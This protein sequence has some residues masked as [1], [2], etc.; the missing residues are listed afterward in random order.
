M[1]NQSLGSPSVSTC[2]LKFGSISS[3]LLFASRGHSCGT[4]SHRWHKHHLLHHQDKCLR[5][6]SIFSVLAIAVTM[7]LLTYIIP[8]FQRTYIQEYF[9]IHPRIDQFHKIRGRNFS[10]CEKILNFHVPLWTLTSNY[11]SVNP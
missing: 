4:Q 1:T 6:S 7:M 10:L 3:N 8:L 9:I 2:N 11:P 5:L